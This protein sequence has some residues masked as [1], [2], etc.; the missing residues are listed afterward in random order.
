[1]KPAMN[2]SPMD[3]PVM[4]PYSTMTVLGGMRM[5][6]VPPAAMQPV[7]RVLAYLNLRISGKATT[8]MVTAQATEEPQMA[9]NPPQAATVAMASPPL[10]LPSQVFTQA[11]SS[12]LMPDLK[13]KLPMSRKRQTTA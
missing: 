2:M 7:A 4:M 1:M 12:S 8:P 13:A 5:P 6:S 9:A 3:C 10:S 11:K